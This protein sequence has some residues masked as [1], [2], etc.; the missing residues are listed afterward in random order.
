MWIVCL[1]ASGYARPGTPGGPRP[2]AMRTVRAGKAMSTC[3]GQVERPLRRLR[4]MKNGS[5][6]LP[7]D[8]FDTVDCF[9]GQYPVL[10]CRRACR[11][12][13]HVR[14]RRPLSH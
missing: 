3:R 9:R 8:G 4:A 2:G 6:A 12:S 11:G 14:W 1:L 5:G 7:V 13:V 10:A